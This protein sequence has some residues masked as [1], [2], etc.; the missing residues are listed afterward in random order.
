MPT[1]APPSL[2]SSEG[3]KSPQ[4]I[5][6][7]SEES[8]QTVEGEKDILNKRTGKEIEMTHIERRAR[9]G[10]DEQSRPTTIY[11][12]KEVMKKLEERDAENH[13]EMDT[14]RTEMKQMMSVIM[15]LSMKKENEDSPK[16][17]DP[18]PLKSPPPIIHSGNP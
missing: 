11:E 7:S 8:F 18:T 1:F 14:M 15:N 17:V 4:S 2:S 13:Q 10:M 6:T 3:N 12:T 9:F 16:I 5:D